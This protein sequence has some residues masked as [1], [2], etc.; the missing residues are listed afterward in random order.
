MDC[1]IPVWHKE[2]RI[3]VRVLEDYSNEAHQSAFAVAIEFSKTRQEGEEQFDHDSS[4][5]EDDFRH[6]M[7][8]T[9]V[10]IVSNNFLQVL[11]ECP[12]IHW[13]SQMLNDPKLC[14]CSCSPI[15]K[16]WR[17]KKKVSIHPNHGCKTKNMTPMQF[18]NHLE[19]EGDST[20]KAILVYLNKLATFQ[21]GPARHIPKKGVSGSSFFLHE[22]IYSMNSYFSFMIL[23]GF[24]LCVN[25]LQQ[26]RILT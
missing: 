24:L 6:V 19:T 5:S 17:E 16:P 14:V 9:R 11:P 7:N 18:L 10:K 22:F 15:T 12:P 1:L 2:I 20:D 21:Q 13:P 4:E 3:P 23:S 25:S 8:P 26:M